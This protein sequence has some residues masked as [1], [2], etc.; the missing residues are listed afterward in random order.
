MALFI[1]LIIAL[2]FLKIYRWD[3]NDGLNKYAVIGGGDGLGYYTYLPAVFIDKNLHDLP[4]NAAYINEIDNRK[5]DRYLIG[6][7]L[8]I[9]PF[10]AA[11][12]AGAWLFDYELS[13]HSSPFQFMVAIAAVFYLFLGLF[14]TIKLLRLFNI[15]HKNI[16]L[17]IVLIL[18][19]TNLLYYGVMACSISHVYSFGAIACF[20]LVVK[21]LLTQHHQKYLY[22]A[23]FLFVLIILVRP[24]NGIV[25]MMIPVLAGSK[26][27]LAALFSFF[28]KRWHHVLY[29]LLIFCSIGFIQLLAWY[30]QTGNFF[31]W[32]YS[33]SG[34]Y[35]TDPQF[36]NVLLSYRKGLFI[37]TPLALI[38]LA[39]LIVVFKKNRFQFYSIL[40]FLLLATYII[41]S[42]W[43]WYYGDSF[44]LRPFIDYY[45]VCGLLLG[46]LLENITHRFGRGFV[47]TVLLLCLSL[48]MIQT[49]QIY[50]GIIHQSAMNFER[51]WQVF[52]RTSDAYSNIFGG[53]IDMQP[54]SK[55]PRKLIYSTNNDFEKEYSRWRTG[56]IVGDKNL[57]NS[58][59]KWTKY[60]VYS[61]NEFG[62]TLTIQNDSLFYNSR[63]IF[64][65]A[66]MRRLE[67]E[68]NSSSQVLFVINI[69]NNKNESA[70][71]YPFRINDQPGSTMCTWQT[72]NYSF[73]LPK[74]KS[75]DDKLLIYLWNKDHQN[76]IVDDF[77]LDFYRLD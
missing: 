11:A 3:G 32:S 67:L 70:F 41:S 25:I 40:S 49:Y 31:V 19:G 73:G 74:L 15:S 5:V 17:V 53:N 26:A 57:C 36:F 18:F 1:S 13:G 9:S 55:K 16:A 7:S 76:F 23:A 47:V 2:A 38:S 30:V 50:N 28:F 68:E 14:C 33:D 37:Y 8:L 63:K 65:E 43:N 44:G 61:E 51:Y 75:L 46:I 24:S 21:K 10:F 39:G 20:A 54:Y 4:S 56:T 58:D 29:S 72:Y 62:A 45:I 42:W 34:F 66:S 64:V 77:K 69:L 27:E 59:Q 22:I 48:N 35:F 12:Y 52:L 60:G 6:A 71:Y